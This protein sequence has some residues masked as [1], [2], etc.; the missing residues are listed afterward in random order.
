MSL[1]SVIEIHPL[2]SPAPARLRVP[3][4]KSIT[5]RA[6]LRAALADGE[7]TLRGALW[8]E[9]TQVMVTCL[10]QLGLSPV[11]SPDPEELGNRSICVRGKAGA[12][13]ALEFLLYP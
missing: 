4:S 9:D 11:A 2:E 7:V 5:N 3:G 12:L 8:S 10:E 1:P 6:L 13:H